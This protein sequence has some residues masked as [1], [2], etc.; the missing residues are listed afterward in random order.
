MFLPKSNPIALLA[1]AE[2]LLA[3]R[4]LPD[5]LEAFRRAEAA[6]ADADRCAAGRWLAHIL[7]GDF[8][9][10]WRESDCIRKRGKPDPHRFWQGEDLNGKRVIVRC[11]HGYGDAV[12]F[13]RYAPL[14]RRMVSRL[15]I[16][17]PP[18]L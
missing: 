12:Q 8:E 15:I 9:N 4:R 7:V 1:E 2:T 6:G 3:A 5:A 16:E 11:L 18:R 10:A 17:V 13:L 14:L